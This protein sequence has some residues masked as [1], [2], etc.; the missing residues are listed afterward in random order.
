MA[1]DQWAEDELGVR[2]GE[3]W[4]SALIPT[5]RTWHASRNGKTYTRDEVRAFYQVNGN[6]FRCHC[7]VTAVLLDANG[8]SILSAGARG[9]LASELAAWKKTYGSG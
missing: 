9:K 2:T 8:K 5:T 4:T 7:S 1:E 6:V 3:L